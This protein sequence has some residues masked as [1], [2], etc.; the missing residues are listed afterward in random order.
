MG[1]QPAVAKLA[2]RPVIVALGNRPPLRTV[3]LPGLIAMR[4]N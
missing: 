4:S 1:S 3:R 2:F